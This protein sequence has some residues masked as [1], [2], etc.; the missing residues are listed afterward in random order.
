MPRPR[1][2]PGRGGTSPRRAARVLR[3]GARRAH[4]RARGD[5]RARERRRLRPR[6]AGHRGGRLLPHAVPRRERRREDASAGLGLK[7]HRRGAE[8]EE[9]AEKDIERVARNPP[10]PAEGKKAP[11][12]EVEPV[13]KK[14]SREVDETPRDEGKAAS[15]ATVAS[16]ASKT[17]KTRSETKALDDRVELSGAVDKKH[18]DP[19]D[20]SSAKTHSRKPRILVAVISWHD[21][22]E[23][24]AAMER[25][26]LGALKDADEHM[27]ADYRVF[28]G[29]YDDANLGGRHAELRTREHKERRG[30]GGDE[31]AAALGTRGGSSPFG[32]DERGVKTEATKTSSKTST[33]SSGPRAR[34]RQKQTTRRNRRRRLTRTRRWTSSRRTSRRRWTRSRR[35]GRRRGATREWA[36]RRESDDASDE[37]SDDASGDSS[38]GDTKMSKHDFTSRL[39]EAVSKA[40]TQAKAQETL[41]A[42]AAKKAAKQTDLKAKPRKEKATTSDAKT[43]KT[44]KA[45]ESTREA[46]REAKTSKTSKTLDSKSAKSAVETRVE[47]PVGDAYEDLPAKVLAAIQ[48]AAEHDY[49]YVY[50]VDTD[51]FVLPEIFL[52]FVK[53][54]VV[55]KNIDWMGSENKM[56]PAYLDPSIDFTDPANAAIVKANSSPSGFKAGLAREWHFGKCTDA[57]L[58]KQ[59]YAGVNPVSVDGGHGYILSKAAAWAVSDFAFKRSDDLQRHRRIDIYEDQLVSHILVKQGFLPV[60]YS[61]V[62]PYK[63]SG[64]TKE[65]ADDSCALADDPGLGAAVGRSAARDARLPLRER[66]EP[67]RNRRGV[68]PRHDG[69]AHVAGVAH[70]RRDPAVRLVRQHG[71]EVGVL[72]RPRNDRATT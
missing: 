71:D 16:K 14:P 38:L 59:R 63:V 50:K 28:V 39:A 56:Y 66:R 42:K 52:K 64:M 5:V 37:T 41:Q 40:K 51:V 18:A 20:Q 65:M 62:A 7:T 72:P 31:L 2:C 23:E 8:A 32:G 27:D 58:N 47:L 26:W 45:A 68:E 10:K 17:S 55:D 70:A 46:T 57:A 54:Q 33:S 49:D 15:N 11:E 6:A 53:T 44:T 43:T 69:R 60:D 25:T 9:D 21:G 12:K 36:I 19:P 35:S 29:E 1:K 22:A 13:A 34:A 24:V 67:V 48:Y 4:L 61:G 30:F 3:G